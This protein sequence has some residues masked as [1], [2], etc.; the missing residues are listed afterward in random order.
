MAS[1]EG[2]ERP[3]FLVIVADDLGFSDCGCFGSE[4]QTPNIDALAAEAGAL[5]FT[6]FHVAAAC[7]PTCSMLMSGTDH[8]ITGLGQLQEFTR[9]S[10]AHRGQ[11]EREGYLHERVVAL[12]GML[13]DGGYYT[14]M[15]GKWHL[16][17]KPE[18]FPIHR[19]FTKSFAL[20]PS[21]A[22]QYG[23]YS[24]PIDNAGIC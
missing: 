24:L 16:G 13:Q 15:S 18:H 14:V 17:L 5:R 4:I 22:N 20:L 7:S 3:N 6:E 21:C 11:K 9:H 10:P 19:G 23:K 1:S 8:H 12:P 2:A